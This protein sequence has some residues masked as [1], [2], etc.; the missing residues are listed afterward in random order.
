MSFLAFLGTK[1]AA[2]I[3]GLPQLPSTAGAGSQTLSPR[4]Q[5]MNRNPFGH[6]ALSFSPVRPKPVTNPNLP[7]GGAPPQITGSR[8]PLQRMN[9]FSWLTGMSPQRPEHLGAAP[10]APAAA[11]TPAAASPPVDWRKTRPGSAVNPLNAGLGLLNIA[12]LGRGGMAA[13]PL[14][15]TLGSEV[16]G[17]AIGGDYFYNPERWAHE[18]TQTAS[19]YGSPLAGELPYG[20]LS[21]AGRP[22]H[23]LVNAVPWGLKN[24]PG[25]VSQGLENR[26]QR[27]GT[28]W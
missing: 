24:V 10:P 7:P 5:W 14:L 19:N 2:G 6:G 22:L 25:L 9:E 27:L 12:T 8:N 17:E 16:A 3:P 11:A 1:A 4:E 21:A 13:R 15:T 26:R 28:S 18:H 23:T 20:M